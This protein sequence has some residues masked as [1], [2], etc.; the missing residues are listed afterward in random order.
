MQN[1]SVNTSVG[2][3]EKVAKMTEEEFLIFLRDEAGK[4]LDVAVSQTLDEVADKVMAEKEKVVLESEYREVQGNDKE[5]GQEDGMF[6][7]NYGQVNYSGEKEGTEERSEEYLRN[8]VD[9]YGAIGSPEVQNV[10][11]I[12]ASG[13][14]VEGKG[15]I[16]SLVVQEKAQAAAAIPEALVS[17]IRASPRLVNSSD[18]HI[19]KKVEK[20]RAEKNLETMEGTLQGDILGKVLV[21]AI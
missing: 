17:L 14:E 4:I 13:P 5:E 6:F 18:E 1:K 9:K 3:K 2:L 21:A 11:Q 12:A 7:E 10:V 15:I 16:D 19:L 8:R 20:R